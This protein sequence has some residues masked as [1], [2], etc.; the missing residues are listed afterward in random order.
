MTTTVFLGKFEIAK[1][2]TIF[3]N[4]SWVSGL[5]IPGVFENPRGG[6]GPLPGNF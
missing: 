6:G 1:S 3:K 2:F 4:L 5:K